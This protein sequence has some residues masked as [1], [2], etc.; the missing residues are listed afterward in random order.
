MMDSQYGR[1][2]A[3]RQRIDQAHLKYL[4]IIP[5]TGYGRS[6][7]SRSLSRPFY[8]DAFALLVSS[9]RNLIIVLL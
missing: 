4:A 2:E 5:T 6:C 9:I 1:N 3:L 8:L 7:Y